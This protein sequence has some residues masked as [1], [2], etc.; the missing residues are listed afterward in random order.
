MVLFPIGAN[1]SRDAAMETYAANAADQML[2]YLRYR[3]NQNNAQW[4]AYI[5]TAGTSLPDKNPCNIEDPEAPYDLQKNTVWPSSLSG[6]A[7]NVFEHASNKGVFQVISS[8][9][10]TPEV[11]SPNVDFRAIMNVWRSDVVSQGH[12]FTL[13]W[14]H[15]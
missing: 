13:T 8:R 2:N 4:E 14:P 11:D 1:A 3:I 15:N 5:I 6:I 7:D 9:D 10:P 12:A